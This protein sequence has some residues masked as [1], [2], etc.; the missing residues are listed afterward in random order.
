MIPRCRQGCTV[1]K[2]VCAEGKRLYRRARQL[3]RW[4]PVVVDPRNARHFCLLRLFW[5]AGDAYLEHI[6]RLRRDD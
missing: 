2:P 4:V 1:G 6:G 5:A 3:H